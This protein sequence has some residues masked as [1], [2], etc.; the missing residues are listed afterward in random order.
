MKLRIDK[1]SPRRDQVT[2]GRRGP[3]AL[4]LAGHRPRR[5]DHRRGDDIYG[6]VNG[7]AKA[8]DGMNTL[9]SM[10]GNAAREALLGGAED[11]WTCIKR[12]SLVRLLVRA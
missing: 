2:R 10:L 7:P 1:S 9:V 4:P 3:A 11:T 12:I 5:R 6:P 8:R